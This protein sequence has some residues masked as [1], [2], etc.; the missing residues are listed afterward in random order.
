MQFYKTKTART[1]GATANK[2]SKI[3]KLSAVLIPIKEKINLKI[4]LRFKYSFFL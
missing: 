4:L 1:I 2:T 3:E